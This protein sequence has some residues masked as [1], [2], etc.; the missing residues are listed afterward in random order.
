MDYLKHTY[1]KLFSVS[2]K[3]K[4]NWLFYI[5]SEN[6]VSVELEIYKRMNI[7]FNVMTLI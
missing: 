5:L 4:F 7:W 6:L 2:L 1:T 3:F